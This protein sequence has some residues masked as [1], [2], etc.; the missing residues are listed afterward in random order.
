MP[1][2]KPRGIRLE[3]KKESGLLNTLKRPYAVKRVR[4]PLLGGSVPCVKEGDHV[5]LGQKIA[6]PKGPDSVPVYASLAGRIEKI[7]VTRLSDGQ[8]CTCAEILSEGESKQAQFAETK[9]DGEGLSKEEI[10]NT[11]R[12][13]G[14]LSADPGM[15][16][17]HAKIRKNAPVR[18][19]VMKC[20]EPEPYTTSGQVLLASHPVE[21]LKGTDLLKKAAG[22]EKAV[23]VFEDANREEYEL[24][25]SKIYLLKWNGYEAEMVPSVYPP[26]HED[27]WRRKLSGGVMTW[28]I[29]TAYAAYEAV[30]LRKPFFERVVTVGGEC[31]AEPRNLWLPFGF[32]FQDAVQ[33]CKGFLREPR[34]VLSGGPMTGTAQAGLDV[35]VTAGTNAILA[36]PGQVARETEE[37]PCIRCNRCVDTCP[38]SISP[39]MIALAAESGE[40]Q[41]AEEWGARDCIECGVCGYVCP[42]EKNMAKWIRLAKEKTG[43]AK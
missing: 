5:H 40:F 15:E 22:A 10:L 21:I 39:A 32:S 23:L 43:G 41:A 27:L 42:S 25:K 33:A 18:T 34:K 29:P 19:I 2:T 13:R 4:V 3:R 9:K 28:N 37:K 8:E 36:L 26:Y 17:V 24:I 20:C 14:L 30:Y 16:P 38:V 11:F 12:E 1:F 35:P 7:T 31:V 6:D